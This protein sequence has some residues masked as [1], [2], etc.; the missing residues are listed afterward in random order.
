MAPAGSKRQEYRAR[1]NRAIDY[2]EAHLHEPLKLEDV[3]AAAFFSPYHFHRIFGSMV[4]E[5]LGDFIQRVRLEKAARLLMANPGMSVTRIAMDCGYG[6]SAAFARAFRKAHGMTASEW[7]AGGHTEKSKN[8]KTVRKDGE[9]AGAPAP[10]AGGTEQQGDA[11]HGRTAMPDVKPLDVKVEAIPEMPVA[12]VR[13]IG[14][15]AGDEALFKRL[16][17]QLMAW[18]GPRNL[19]RFPQTQMLVV[20]HD[21]PGITDDAKLR[22]SVCITVPEGTEGSGEVGTMTLPG[23]Q[24]ARARFELAGNEYGEAWKAVFGGWLPDSGY[25]PDDRPAYELYL[26]NPEEHPEGKAILDICV[27]VRPL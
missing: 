7:R 26:N 12:Y 4:G 6:S 19:L 25:Q 15:Y 22:I 20:Y 16:F 8:G 24:T 18:A 3:A 27:P 5:T 17:G 23:G 9:E 10:Y 1:I 14:P 21:D 13:H 11:S 2:I